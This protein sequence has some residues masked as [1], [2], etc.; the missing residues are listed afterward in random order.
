MGMWFEI[1]PPFAI[2]VGAYMSTTLLVQTYWRA[3]HGVVSQSEN[4]TD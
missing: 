1:I 4:V 3:M 2:M